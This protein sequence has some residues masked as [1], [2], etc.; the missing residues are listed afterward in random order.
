MDVIT[1]FLTGEIAEEI[2]MNQPEG[3]VVQGKEQLVC[4]LK[5]SIHDL[6]Q[7]PRCWNS[8]LDNKLKSM[9]FVQTCSDA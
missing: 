8:I 1:A 3:F 2:Y 5:K 4:R 9:G 6:K 7:L